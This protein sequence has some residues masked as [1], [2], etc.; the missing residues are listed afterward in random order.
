MATTVGLI[1]RPGAGKRTLFELVTGRP[2]ED[3]FLKAGVKA[4]RASVH[5]PDD[6]LTA[7]GRI[8]KPKKV[9]PAQFE[10]MYLPGF[11]PEDDRKIVTAALSNYRTCQ[12]LALVVNLFTPESRDHAEKET[13]ELIDE[14]ILLDYVQLESMLPMLKKRVSGKEAQAAEKLAA[15]K[16][17]KTVLEDGKPASSTELPAFEEALVKEYAF[18]TSRPFLIVGNV[19]DDCIADPG[20]IGE[21]FMA[22]ASSYDAGFITVSAKIEAEL[23]ALDEEGERLELMTEFGID[24]SGIVRLIHASHKLLSLKTFFTGGDIEVRARTMHVDGTAYDAAA[25][26]HS[27]L[28]KGFIR[29][30]IYDSHD[31]IKHGGL[32]ALRG[33]E[34]MKLAGKE[35]VI[36]EGDYVFIR[37]GV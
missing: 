21:I 1:G 11:T 31:V 37:S 24:E 2:P 12:A 33:T 28:A 32:Q 18:V 10:L 22:L 25:I 19:S 14:L 8:F 34:M 36:K 35:Y 17:I 27:D 26:V 9:T 20:E 5:V 7:L 6:R 30:E 23:A 3:I 29:A 4:Q 13:R 16:K 15:L